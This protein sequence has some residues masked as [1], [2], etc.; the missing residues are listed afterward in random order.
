MLHCQTKHPIWAAIEIS[1]KTIF[2]SENILGVE[3]QV[4]ARCTL[5][6]IARWKHRIHNVGFPFSF[7]SFPIHTRQSHKRKFPVQL[8]TIQATL[9]KSVYALR[10][11]PCVRA[12][13]RASALCSRPSISTLVMRVGFIAHCWSIVTPWVFQRYQTSS[14]YMQSII[15]KYY[16]MK[17]LDIAWKKPTPLQY[18][19]SHIIFERLMITICVNIFSQSAWQN[20]VI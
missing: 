9:V 13:M 5:L 20:W 4:I 16:S 7:K 12:C 3:T 6:H 10:F 17:I 14:M 1:W 19:D 2:L 15:S 11:N 18:I 8:H